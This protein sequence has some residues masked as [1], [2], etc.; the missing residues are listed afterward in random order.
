MNVEPRR[1]GCHKKKSERG[2]EGC[3]VKKAPKWKVLTIVKKTPRKAVLRKA[4]FNK[5]KNF[6]AA[7]ATKTKEV[8]QH[9]KSQHAKRT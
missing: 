6:T 9:Y 8:Q 3:G 5:R 7:I 1:F 4:I 2:G